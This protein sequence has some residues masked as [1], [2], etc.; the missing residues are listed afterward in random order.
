MNKP[1]TDIDDPRL[2]KALAHPLRVRILALLERGPATPKQLA[3]ALQAPLENLSYHVR[4][5]RDFGFI[6]L[7]ERRMVRG[8][9]EHQ[10]RLGARPRITARA[11]ENLPGIVREAL[12][13][14]SLGQIWDVV[15]Q[16]AVQGKMDRPESHVARQYARLD[17]QGFAEAS[18]LVTDL[19]DRLAEIEKASEERLRAHETVEVPTT[20]IAMLFDAPDLAPPAGDGHG[21]AASRQAAAAS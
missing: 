20:L 11:W 8:A 14:A 21:A 6:D 1:I 4:T 3:S 7:E 18:A 16:A 19:L 2:V 17:E 15:S 9:V 10:Y 12:D 5:L 13:A